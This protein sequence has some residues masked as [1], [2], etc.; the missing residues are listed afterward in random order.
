VTLLQ[1]EKVAALGASSWARR[2]FKKS[3]ALATIRV[4]LEL[5]LLGDHHLN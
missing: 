2:V 4:N 3:N 5:D 1:L